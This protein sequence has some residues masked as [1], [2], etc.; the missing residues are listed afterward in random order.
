MNKTAPP[1]TPIPVEPAQ[2]AR[3]RGLPRNQVPGEPAQPNPSR[4]LPRNRIPAQHSLSVALAA[5]PAAAGEARRCVRKAIE[6]WGAPADP[7][8]AALLTSELVTNAIRHSGGP[9]RLFVTCSCGHLRVYVHDTSPEWPAPAENSVEA[10]DGRGLMLVAS[11]A[12]N[13]GCY[14]TSVGKAVYFT[15]AL[16][17]DPGDS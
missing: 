12:T 1:R 13:W 15:L 10:E 2:P 17:S 7:Y 3:L 8:V 4:A 14:S 11:L 9:I 6:T 16:A 5:G